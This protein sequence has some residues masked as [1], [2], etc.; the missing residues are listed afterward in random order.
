MDATT[1][2]RAV[3]A[4]A[5]AGAMALAAAPAS[6]CSLV[7]IST[8]H[9]DAVDVAYEDGTLETSVHDESVEPDVERDP[10]QVVLV[11]LPGA[12]TEVPDDEAYSFLGDAG[13]TVWVLPEVQD[14]SL[15]WPGFSAEEIEDG[16]FVD[17]E[18]DVTFTKFRGPD[19]VSVFDAELDGS[20]H[21]L[22]DSE[23]RQADVVTLTAGAHQHASWAFEASGTYRLTYVVTG[24]LADSGETISSEPTTIT[25]SVQE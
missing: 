3:L 18:L 23:D 9:V 4:T 14:E 15:L 10:A 7:T 21:L 17:D 2:R 8:G 5:T 1:A 13:D 25:F 16:V 12:Q 11:A 24:T 19:G 6:A 20:P 22:L